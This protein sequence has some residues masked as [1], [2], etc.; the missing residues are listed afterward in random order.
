MI[1]RISFR[2]G[3]LALWLVVMALPAMAQVRTWRDF[4]GDTIQAA[5]VTGDDDAITVRLDNGRELRIP[6]TTL[7]PSD[8]AYAQGLVDARKPR[9]TISG[10]VAWTV[11]D[12]MNLEVDTDGTLT[13][14]EYDRAEKKA[15]RVLGSFPY[16]LRSVQGGDAQVYDASYSSPR[17]AVAPDKP[18]LLRFTISYRDAEG[19]RSQLTRDAFSAGL[20]PRAGGLWAGNASFTIT[21]QQLAAAAAADGGNGPGGSTRT[22]WIVPTPSDRAPAGLPDQLLPPGVAATERQRPETARESVK[23]G[24]LG[25]TVQDEPPPGLPNAWR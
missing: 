10:T 2:T 7:S 14:Y 15:G 19:H 20:K 6:M 11:G 8:R 13:V 4:T 17:L 3:V 21:A 23:E 22:D 16:H 1:T 24:A 25:E 18:V 9:Y 5:F 12:G